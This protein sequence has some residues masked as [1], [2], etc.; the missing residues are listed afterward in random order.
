MQQP[1]VHVHSPSCAFCA[2]A[3]RS[4]A[5]GAPDVCLKWCLVERRKEGS[6]RCWKNDGIRQPLAQK[7]GANMRLSQSERSPPPGCRACFAGPLPLARI[8]CTVVCY[9]IL[10]TRTTHPP[11]GGCSC[12]A[13]HAEALERCSKASCT[14]LPSP[15]VKHAAAVHLFTWLPSAGVRASALRYR[16]K[17]R[18]VII[19]AVGRLVVAVLCRG[20]QR[21][22]AG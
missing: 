12:T 19:I 16:L 18:Q 2:T 10:H 20:R 5:D 17:V 15:A 9:R 1:S 22:N 13:V 7:T 4:C 3:A 11:A 21:G 8:G 6:K 14:V